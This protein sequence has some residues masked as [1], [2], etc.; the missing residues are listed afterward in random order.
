MFKKMFMLGAAAL[1]ATASNTVMAGSSP[2]TVAKIDG[3]LKVVYTD[4]GKTEGSTIIRKDGANTKGLIALALGYE[5]DDKSAE[6][7]AATRNKVLA[8]AYG[9]SAFEVA[10]VVWD[11]VEQ[12]IAGILGSVEIA[13]EPAVARPA[14]GVAGK[15]NAYAPAEVSFEDDCFQ[16]S[17]LSGGGYAL[18]QLTGKLDANGQLT[19]GNL[20][21]LGLV[22]SADDAVITDGAFKG[23]LGKVLATDVSFSCN[24]QNVNIN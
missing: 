18:V 2:I 20:S 9:E 11:T 1:L 15:V 7:K 3:A 10:L 12:E 6:A 21:I 13:G 16:Q 5:P 23:N 17:N 4:E 8:A 22:G 24:N 19:P 14:D